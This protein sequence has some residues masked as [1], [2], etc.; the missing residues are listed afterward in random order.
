MRG[1]HDG[2]RRRGRFGLHV[3]VCDLR[4]SVPLLIG[5]MLYNSNDANGGDYSR[6]SRLSAEMRPK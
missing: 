4:S 3:V 2:A 1:S 5:I 6:L